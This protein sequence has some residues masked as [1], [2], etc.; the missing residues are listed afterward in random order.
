[1]EEHGF[2]DFRF[3]KQ[4]NALSGVKWA[5]LVGIWKTLAEGDLNC[6]SLALEVSE[7]NF[8]MWPRAYSCDILVKN[9]VASCPVN[10][11]CLRLR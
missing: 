3:R 11:V 10:R 7:K 1:L 2:G 8:S 4:W 6:R 5:I 9:F